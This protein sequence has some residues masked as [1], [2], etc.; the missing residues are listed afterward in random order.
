MR[1]GKLVV[2]GEHD[3][4]GL[5][6]AAFVEQ[7]HEELLSDQPLE[8]AEGEPLSGFLARTPQQVEAALI[9]Q[10]LRHANVQEGAENGLARPALVDVRSQLLDATGRQRPRVLDPFRACGAR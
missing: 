8:F 10:P 6:G 5:D 3:G 9:H 2:L 1:A 7:Q 4:N